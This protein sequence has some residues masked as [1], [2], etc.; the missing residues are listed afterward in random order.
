MDEGGA[1]I[2]VSDNRFEKAM[3]SAVENENDVS[4]EATNCQLNCLDGL[5]CSTCTDESRL[6]YTWHDSCMA[7]GFVRY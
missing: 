3:S 1:E 7:C 5:F 6:N 4:D 2:T